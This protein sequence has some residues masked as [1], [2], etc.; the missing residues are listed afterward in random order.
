MFILFFAL[1]VITREKVGIKT[2]RTENRFL[3]GPG[4][5]ATRRHVRALFSPGSEGV[6]NGDAWVS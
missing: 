6:K 5:Y 3:T 1:H 2:H 4:K